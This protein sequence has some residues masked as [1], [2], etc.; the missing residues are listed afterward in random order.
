MRNPVF[1]LV[2]K[3]RLVGMGVLVLG[4]L[5]GCTD[6]KQPI[7]RGKKHDSQ[8][9]TDS[10]SRPGHDAS[11]LTHERSSAIPVDTAENSAGYTPSSVGTSQI[12]GSTADGD[13]VIREGETGRRKPSLDWSLPD[14]DAW[15]NNSEVAEL[16]Y[17]GGFS[18]FRQQLMESYLQNSQPLSQ[19]AIEV[20][21]RLLWDESEE[22]IDKPL[23]EVLTGAEVEI[24]VRLP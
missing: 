18:G 16:E 11:T 4:L 9:T 3:T 22:A 8:A 17:A 24:R 23:E 10:G 15:L 19:Q 13:S 2:D 20:S 21:G 14:D 12:A 5:I 6:E 7:F 1:R